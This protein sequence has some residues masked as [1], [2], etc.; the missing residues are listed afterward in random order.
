[1]RATG[2]AARSA[3]QSLGIKLEL[4]NGA[5]ES[6]TVHTKLASSFALIS[7]T[8]LQDRQYEFLLEFANRFRVGNAAAIH[9]HH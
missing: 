7:I 6:I 5:A 4:C 3:T 2:R 8:V 1:M 9:L